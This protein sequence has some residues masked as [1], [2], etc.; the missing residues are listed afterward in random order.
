MGLARE[1]RPVDTRTEE[2][3]RRHV[4]VLQPLIDDL[5][6]GNGLR[7]GDLDLIAVGIGPGPFTGLRIGIVTARTLGLVAG[8]EVRGF[9]TL[10]AIA[11]GAVAPGDFVVV[12]DARRKELYWARYDASG[13]RVQG[14]EVAPPEVIPDLPACG[15]GVDVYPDIFADRYFEGAPRRLD[16]ALVAAHIHSLPDEGLEPAYLRQPDAETPRTRK[17]ALAVGRLRLPRTQ[18]TR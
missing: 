9:G 11:L 2:S 5:L 13:R 6:A 3:S 17:S 8:V 4:E 7:P 16:A 15:P 1:G 14:P 12:T 18:V 10:D